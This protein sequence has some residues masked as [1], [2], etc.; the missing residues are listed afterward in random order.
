M[1]TPTL[2]IPDLEATDQRSTMP[3]FEALY[4]AYHAPIR[5]YVARTVYSAAPADP[6]MVEDIVQDTFIKVWRAYPGDPHRQQSYG[7]WIFTIARHTCIDWLRKQQRTHSHQE[8][9]T[10]WHACHLLAA[11]DL[12]PVE[13]RELLCSAC[14]TLR[15]RDA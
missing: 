12:L 10:E 11:D 3:T 4:E 8:A 15:T 13:T 6:D 14:L 5:R 9:L 2:S 7:P 1:K